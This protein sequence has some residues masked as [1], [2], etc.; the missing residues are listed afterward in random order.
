MNI[1]FQRVYDS[2]FSRN[3]LQKVKDITELRIGSQFLT[4]KKEGHYKHNITRYSY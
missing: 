2:I 3:K 4:T 1:R